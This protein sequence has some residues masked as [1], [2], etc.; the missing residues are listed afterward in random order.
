[1]P[2]IPKK[3]IDRLSSQVPK[4]QRVLK[5]SKVRDINE[6]DTVVIVGDILSNVFGFDK[7]ED[8]TSEFAIRN[9]FCD[10]AIRVDGDTKYLIEVKA[11]GL[12]LKENHLRQ[13]VNYGANEG[14]QWVVLTNGIYW[15][16]YRILFEKPINHE[17]VVSLNFLDL[18]MKKSEDQGH[19][20]LLCKEG[21]AKSAIEKYHEHHQHVNRF[22]IG[23]IIQSESVTKII[24]RDL[25]KI[26]P[27]LKIELK[28]IDFLLSND[29]L[30]RDIVESEDAKKALKL[31]KRKV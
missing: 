20:F 17:L 1:M 28:E 6:A 8:V 24:R 10:L 18:K 14:V 19:L 29:V 7:Y 25:R 30:K 4:F 15:D 3:V 27:G 11:I 5:K 22:V 2:N 26:S 16:I 21:L 31:V 9:T 13:T 12:D 23:A